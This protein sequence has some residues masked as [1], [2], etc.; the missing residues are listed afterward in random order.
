MKNEDAIL[1]I[2]MPDGKHTTTG[3][4]NRIYRA[5][6]TKNER[7][8]NDLLVFPGFVCQGTFTMDEEQV[9]VDYGWEQ[10]IKLDQGMAFW[11]NLN[12]ESVRYTTQA[13]DLRVFFPKSSVLFVIKN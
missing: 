9:L 8:N 7:H 6:F 5:A 13:L 2:D 12:K 3:E 1:M 10:F 4:G 11:R